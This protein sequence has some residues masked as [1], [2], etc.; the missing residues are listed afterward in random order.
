MS[1]VLLSTTSCYERRAIADVPPLDSGPPSATAASLLLAYP[2]KA[3]GCDAL[4][5][6][7]C[8]RAEARSTNDNPRTQTE[9]N[10]LAYAKAWV[11]ECKMRRTYVGL[12]QRLAANQRAVAN[13]E[14][15]QRRWVT[16]TV[17]DEK[18]RFPHIDEPGFYGSVLP[19]CL[20]IE[21]ERQSL[22][23][24]E[25]LKASASCREDPAARAA[26]TEAART[27]DVALNDAYRKIR[28]AFGKDAKFISAL[29]RAEQ[30]WIASR[31]A[32][33]AFAA[34]A[35]GVPEGTCAM[36]ELA[37]ATRERTE[38]LRGW[39]QPYKEGDA[40]AGSHAPP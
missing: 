8:A 29:T 3:V 24:N 40:C 34:S 30:M 36:R 4:T 21:E 15:A 27:A 32:Q 33:L 6:A 1:G 23:G 11:A 17:H 12:M 16:L 26:A 19:I 18:A 39:L 38:F 13:L 2:S 10:E 9:A 28:S 22:A 35:S 20:G 14:E 37:G 7:D 25:A 31:D 5:D